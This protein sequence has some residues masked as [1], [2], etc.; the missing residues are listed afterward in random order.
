M[1]NLEETMRR[2]VG[3]NEWLKTRLSELYRENEYLTF[4]RFFGDD[5]KPNHDLAGLSPSTEMKLEK[6][7]ERE[8]EWEERMND[9]REQNGF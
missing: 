4:R 8:R 1:D 3:E 5:F 2:L 7:M 9:G 6:L